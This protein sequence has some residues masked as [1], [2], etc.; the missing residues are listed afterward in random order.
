M[1]RNMF[2]KLVYLTT[3]SCTHWLVLMIT[4]VFVLLWLIACLVIFVL[5]IVLFEVMYSM[6][7][8][9]I[10]TDWWTSLSHFQFF[11]FGDGYRV[12][13]K[14]YHHPLWHRSRDYSD[15]NFHV[16]CAWLMT[17]AFYLDTP[18][19]A[20]QAWFLRPTVCHVNH[21]ITPCPTRDGVW[22]L[23]RVAFWHWRVQVWSRYDI[24]QETAQV[25]SQVVCCYDI[26]GN[27]WFPM[28]SRLV[29][30]QRLSKWWWLLKV[31]RFVEKPVLPWDN[32]CSD[33]NWTPSLR[34]FHICTPMWINRP[35][36]KH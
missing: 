25:T 31:S 2:F 7:S 33:R 19:H 10:A 13:G 5:Y 35:S 28:A 18:P 15:N 17:A 12:M 11:F 20:S 32:S 8:G 26:A 4:P 9:V 36:F 3:F 29:E 23:G 24:P 34:N 16:V 22:T 21:D 1:E 27:L 6:V 14:A 30:T